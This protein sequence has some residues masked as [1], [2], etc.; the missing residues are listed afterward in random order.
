MDL[1]DRL[2]LAVGLSDLARGDVAA[3]LDGFAIPGSLVRPA[4]WHLTLRFLGSSDE[5]TT[6]RVIG[7]VAQ[8]PLGPPLVMTLHGLGAFPN[9]RRATVIWIGVTRGEERL[10]ELADLCEEAAQ[11]AGFP[12]ED[13]PFHPHLTLSRVRPPENVVSLLE[14]DPPPSVRTR[15]ERVTLFR[16]R[17][18]RG[19]AVYEPVE[20]FPLS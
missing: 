7:A 6:D 13:R 5:V 8:S 10:A 18:G 14:R 17:L 15:V 20:D 9:P 11:T 1:T 4:G 19:G 2:F 3:A 16:S 12:P